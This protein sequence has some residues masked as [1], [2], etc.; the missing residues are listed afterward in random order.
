MKKVL[1]N[2]KKVLV[3]FDEVLTFFNG[4]LSLTKYQLFCCED[5]RFALF[6]KCVQQI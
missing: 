6:H 4:V 5:N 3:F 2:L 1:D